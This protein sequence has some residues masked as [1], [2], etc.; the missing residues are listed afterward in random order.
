MNA[1]AK[2]PTASD[3]RIRQVALRVES[4]ENKV[5]DINVC[6]VLFFEAASRCS[7]AAVTFLAAAQSRIVCSNQTVDARNARPSLVTSSRVAMT[8]AKV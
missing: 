1:E 7:C 2:N 3:V 6:R 8:T 5:D 4:A